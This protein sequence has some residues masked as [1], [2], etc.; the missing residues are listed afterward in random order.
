[1]PGYVHVGPEYPLLNRGMFM[2]LIWT[3]GVFWRP[4][5]NRDRQPTALLPKPRIYFGMKPPRRGL[6]LLMGAFSPL[7]RTPKPDA[8]ARSRLGLQSR[9]VFQEGLAALN[10][11]SQL[12]IENSL[13]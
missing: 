5:K 8:L 9:P 2:V 6:P 10:R 13:G 11:P 12:L 7:L 1:M 3:I 4:I